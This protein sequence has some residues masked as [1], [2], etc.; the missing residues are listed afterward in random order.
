[1]VSAA[2]EGDTATQVDTAYVVQTSGQ[3]VDSRS[4][5]AQRAVVETAILQVS[6]RRLPVQTKPNKTP[7]TS[8]KASRDHTGS[9]AL[10]SQRK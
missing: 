6:W 5:G 7:E 8:V 2:V 3:C 9:L 4:E 1:M 10:R